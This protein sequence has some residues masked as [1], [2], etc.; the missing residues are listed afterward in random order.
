[1]KIRM[2]IIVATVSLGAWMASAE[3][4]PALPF[5]SYLVQGTFK[6]VYNTV[7][8]DGSITA[9]RAQRAD[10]TVIAEAKVASANAEGVNFVM[11]IPVAS[12]STPSACT[13]SE[14]LDCVLVNKEGALDV[15]NCLKVA[16]PTTVGKVVFN[17]TEVKSFTNPA[18]GS[19]IEIPTAYID[20]V[21]SYLP[22]GEVYDPW[23]D[24]DNDGSIN[25]YEFRNGTNP[26]DPSDYLRVLAFG[27]KGGKMA[28]KFEHVG[29]HVYAVSSVNALGKPAWAKRR[30]RKQA[31]GDELEQVVAEDADGEPGA[32]EIYI[33]PVADAASEFFK[34]EGK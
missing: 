7:L 16:S 28:L 30:V 3:T 13:V 1:M 15:P 19:V 12:A 10:G 5:G 14:S 8:R 33:T 2:A 23:K 34:L 4:G 17:C 11:E 18:D 26:F 32:T 24:Y 20:E 31:D 21:L 22:H 9:V 25:F 27:P 6:G 29:G